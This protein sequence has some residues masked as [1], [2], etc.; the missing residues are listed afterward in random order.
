MKINI[1]KF[2]A[3][4][5]VALAS[6]AA[7]TSCEDYL[8][9]DPDSTVG[10]DLAFKDY[11]NF[12]GFLD[13]VYNCVPNKNI[14]YWTA[15]WN[16]GEDEYLVPDGNWHML[17]QVDLGDFWKWQG[18][19]LGQAGFWFD[20]APDR[21]NP[22][23]N[24]TD[25]HA[26]YGH[27]WY[28][29]RKCN[30]GLENLDNMVGTNEERQLLKGQ[31][32][33]FRA[34]W[35]FEMMQ[36]LGGLPYLDHTIPASE[37]PTEPRL[38]FQECADRCAADFR[39]AANLL[40]LDWDQ[41]TVGR[42][43]LGHNEFRINK[44][45]A[46]GYLGK[47]YLWAGSPLMVNGPQ[48]GGTHTYDYDN[49]YCEKAA[50]AFGELLTLVESGQTLYKLAS[51]DYKSV[52]D[53]EKNEGA[54]DCYSDIFFSRR[55][56]GRVP[57]AKESMFRAPSAAWANG[58]P[59][60]YIMYNYAATFCPNWLSG[61]RDNLVHH[62][63][64]NYVEYYGMANGMP[65]DDPDS[66]YD[67][68]HPYKDRDPRFYHDIIYDGSTFINGAAEDDDK[69]SSLYTGGKFRNETNASSTGYLMNKLVCHTANNVDQVG[70]QWG[71]NP[72][73]DIPYMRLADIY[74]MYAEAVGASQGANGKSNN[75]GRTAA[76]AV[77]VVRDRCGAGH[78]A[79]KYTA[80]RT[81]FLDE[82]RRERAVELAFEGLRFNDLQRW[83]LLT[84]PKYTKKTAHEFKRVETID[85][86]KENDASEARIAELE[87]RVLLV[88]PFTAKHY[89][90]PLKREETQLYEG[91][92]QN[93]GW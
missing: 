15:T 67:I 16:L 76:D 51:W 32:L 83:L 71:D 88:R 87:E 89:W 64:A 73:A 2:L 75:F 33:F 11:T 13:E 50:Q 18:G 25:S 77:N 62:P 53:H 44:A 19:S 90:F 29:I 49:A 79:D 7:L 38:S 35:H 14:H 34:W 60:S 91:Y 47:C 23:S 58:G 65:I 39:E 92:E 36:F 40:P 9:K 63:T 56:Q 84:E 54:E 1:S 80:S 4:A 12:Q 22:R 82:V 45:M 55:N 26:L 41:T 5:F 24:N 70:W 21:L 68:T 42:K 6:T 72:N 93:P 74:L 20:K 85:W 61:G 86:F 46:L 43:T 37:S 31:M 66:G 78:V 59:N 30:M 27:A 10:A 48:T 17:H 52:F 81:L 28:C 3:G 69:Y 8:D 57:G